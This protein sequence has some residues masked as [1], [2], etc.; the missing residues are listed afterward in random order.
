MRDLSEKCSYYYD[1]L[2]LECV[3]LLLLLLCERRYPSHFDISG[4]GSSAAVRDSLGSARDIAECV[5]GDSVIGWK[6]CLG[7]LF[8]S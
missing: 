2:S 1:R 5:F 6:D 3:A 4:R 8:Y 7:T